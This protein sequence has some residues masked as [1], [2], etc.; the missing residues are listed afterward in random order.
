MNEIAVNNIPITKDNKSRFSS[1][2]WLSKIEELCITLGGIGGIGSWTALLLSRLEPNRINLYDS[3]KVEYNNLS[4]QFYTLEDVSKYKVHAVADHLRQF[5][6]YYNTNTCPR[7]FDHN[8]YTSPIMIGGFDNMEARRVFF[9]KWEETYCT[10]TWRS[11]GALFI[12]GRLAAEEFQV[13]CI[14]NDDKFNIERYKNEFLFN[15][16]EVEQ[17]ICSYKQ[18]SYCATMIASYIVNLL[19]N[20]CTNLEVEDD[21]RP[22]PFMTSY[23][24]TTMYLKTEL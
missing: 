3:D 11:T 24:A 21:I 4:G 23:N 1:A 12:D 6:A 20:Y 13:F 22:L 7:L 10:D 9:S 2:I 5:S 17:T 19:V 14:K 16:D 8:S 18:T 15:D